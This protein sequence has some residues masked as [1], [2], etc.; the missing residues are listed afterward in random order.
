MHRGGE[1]GARPRCVARAPAPGSQPPAGQ[2]ARDAVRHLHRLQPLTHSLNRLIHPRTIQS[3]STGDDGGP[4][5]HAAH[6][7]ST[8]PDKARRRSLPLRL[9]HSDDDDKRLLTTPY[10][11]TATELT[12]S[13]FSKLQAQ[14]LQQ[15]QRRREVAPSPP[16]LFAPRRSLPHTAFCTTQA[17]LGARGMLK[18]FFRPPPCF[19]SN[20]DSRSSAG[21]VVVT[22]NKNI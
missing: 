1:D 21:D 16:P 19:Y 13:A 10:F 12:H 7:H 8:T 2:P 6:L 15:R 5:S 18:T 9:L 4:G 20:S 22:Q 17:P 3:P 11:C 14:R